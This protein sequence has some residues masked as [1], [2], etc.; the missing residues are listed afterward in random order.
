MRINTSKS[1]LTFRT[2]STMDSGLPE[3]R[4]VCGS[5]AG[6]SANIVTRPNIIAD[7]SMLWLVGTVSVLL[8]DNVSDAHVENYQVSKI[9]QLH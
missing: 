9:C 7:Y 5:L 4:I 8:H 6:R 3:R 1:D 2:D